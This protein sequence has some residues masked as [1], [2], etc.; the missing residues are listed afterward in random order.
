MYVNSKVEQKGSSQ[1]KKG[2]N[3]A[4]KTKYYDMNI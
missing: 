4:M 3:R 2:K 1:G